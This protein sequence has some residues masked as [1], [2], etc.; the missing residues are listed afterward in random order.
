[1]ES[2]ASLLG[3]GGANV[4]ERSSATRASRPGRLRPTSASGPAPSL[5]PRT[6]F[7]KPPELVLDARGL[8]S[9]SPRLGFRFRGP[10]AK[11]QRES[12]FQAVSP[13]ADCFEDGA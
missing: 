6:V 10:A 7:D 5:G 3:S 2:C 4:G 13:S 9:M 1:M 8:P 11:P 12:P